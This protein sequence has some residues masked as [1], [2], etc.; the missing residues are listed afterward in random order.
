MASPDRCTLTGTEGEIELHY[1]KSPQLEV[2]SVNAPYN[3]RF[4]FDWK[5]EDRYEVCYRNLLVEFIECV[6]QDRN[7][8]PNAVD[9]LKALEMVL[10]AYQSHRSDCAVKLPMAEGA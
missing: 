2:A 5:G 6:Q 3:G 1:Q 4:Y 8:T 7:P 9:G 10:G